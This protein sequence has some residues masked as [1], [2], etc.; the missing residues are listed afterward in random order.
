MSQLEQ[1]RPTKRQLV[2]DVVREAGIDVS[3]WA[4]YAHGTKPPGA[5]PKYC[6]E[7]AFV[8]PGRVVVLNLW[9]KHMTESGGVVSVRD[10]L[11]AQAEKY[12]GIPKK[13]TWQK[14]AERLD[15]AVRVALQEHL[16]IRAVVLAGKIREYVEM[17]S[18]A[19]K[20][21]KRLLDPVPWAV[22]SYDAITG[23][24]VVTRGALPELLVDQF[25][26]AAPAGPTELIDV[27][28]KAYF[29]D[30]MVRQ[31]ALRR[32]SGRCEWCQEFGFAMLN[33]AVFLETHH[34]VPLSAGGADTIANVVAL[35]ANHHREA[36]FGAAHETM[37]RALLKYLGQSVPRS[38]T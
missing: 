33:G 37:R 1:I 29:R 30:P 20:V 27:V 31:N 36:H 28:G 21:E 25:S 6:Y 11:R 8:E 35:C 2:I 32:A 10:N 14:R 15:S 18:E 16:P 17:E 7:W 24:F 34:V 22:T 19:S 3:D 26:V 23:D 38:A 4:N 5:N 12:A 9:H 13:G